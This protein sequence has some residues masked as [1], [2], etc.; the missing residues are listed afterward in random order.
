MP[1]VD[2]YV[3]PVPNANREA[4]RAMAQKLAPFFIE[5]GALQIV[6]CWG[7]DVPHGTTTDFFTAVKAKE[8]ENVVLSWIIWPD[9][10]TRD[11]G[12]E[13]IMADER[14]KPQAEMPFDGKRMFWG[15]FEP[16][17]DHKA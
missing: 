11:S 6:E 5:C 14:G 17:V 16:I 12:W 15:G 3:L 4:Y 9:K 10:A 1:Y 8:D 2:G 7:D 13:K